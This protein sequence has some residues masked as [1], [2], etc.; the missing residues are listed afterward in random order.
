M[1]VVFLYMSVVLLCAGVL[2][3]SCPLSFCVQVLGRNFI[4]FGLI[5]Q[6][7]RLQERPVVFYLFLVWGS[8]ELLRYPYYALQSAGQDVTMVTWLR[9]TAWIPLYPLGMLLEGQHGF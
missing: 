9:Y 4:L 3:T 5:L 7:P 6:E 2:P 8:V 1:Q